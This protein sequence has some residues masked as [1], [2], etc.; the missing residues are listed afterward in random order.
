MYPK[1]DREGRSSRWQET[2]PAPVLYWRLTDLK[3]AFRVDTT[4][5][6]A[7]TQEILALAEGERQQLAQEVLPILLTTRAGLEG[8]D[9]ALRTLSDKELDAIVERARSRGRDLSETAVAEVI[10]EALRSARASRRS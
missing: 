6:K 1:C 2:T 3:V 7:L 4:K 5:V 8:I 10:D 9:E